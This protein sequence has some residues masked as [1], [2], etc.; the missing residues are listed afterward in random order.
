MTA[1][2]A[3][4]QGGFGLHPRPASEPMDLTFEQSAVEQPDPILSFQEPFA[5]A[6]VQDQRLAAL[7]D[8]LQK[9]WPRRQ[10][11]GISG[12]TPSLDQLAL[13]T[14]HWASVHLVRPLPC[15]RFGISVVWREV[16]PRSA[17]RHPTVTFGGPRRNC[18]FSAREVYTNP[19]Q[20]LASSASNRK[21]TGYSLPGQT[22]MLITSL[23][24][25]ADFTFWQNSD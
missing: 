5:P 8:D 4:M 11:L 2:S 3:A 1:V 18:A 19:L 24:V 16:R 13:P 10:Q 12:I 20:P 23:G 6:A 25:A 21:A 7:V 9:E 17:P 15:A 22:R 14:P